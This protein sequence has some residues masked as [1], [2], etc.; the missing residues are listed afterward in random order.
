MSREISCDWNLKDTWLDICI[1][2]WG[3]WLSGLIAFL[4]RHDEWV[5]YLE[6]PLHVVRCYLPGDNTNLTRGC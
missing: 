4:G 3:S 1:H 2:I 6:K 5:R